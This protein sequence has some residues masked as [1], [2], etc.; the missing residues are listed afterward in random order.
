MPPPPPHVQV[1]L[2]QAFDMLNAGR[3]A[4]AKAQAEKILKA[5]PREPNALYLMGVLAHQAG[6]LKAAAKH[7]EKSFAADKRNPAALSGIG[8]V[9]LDQERF[10]EAVK[11]FEDL[12][13]QMPK[14][15]A[16]LNNLGVAYKGQQRYDRAIPALEAAIAA[17]PDYA[18]AYANLGGLFNALAETQKARKV[19]ETGAARCPRDTSI[20]L[21][22]AETLSNDGDLD[23]AI[24]TLRRALRANPAEREVRSR[25]ASLLIN[26]GGFDEAWS[27]LRALADEDPDDPKVWFDM[28][29]LADA[30]PEGAERSPA[31]FR[32]EGLAVFK[33]GGQGEPAPILAQRLAQ[34][35]EAEKDYAS[36]FRYYAKA[37]DAFKAAQRSVGNVYDRAQ[38]EALY[39]QLIEYFES[40][41]PPDPATI[42]GARA[43][44]RPIFILGMPR[45][46][47]SLLEQVLASHPAI[48]G[49]GELMTVPDLILTR[50]GQDG[51]VPGFI[52]GCDDAD[53]EA[54]AANYLAAL[55]GLD[56]VAD[57]VTDKLPTNFVNTGLIRLM[58]PDATIL[59][60][61]R[62][63]LDVSWSV[64]VQKFGANLLF[65][66]DLGDIGHYYRQYDR[67][68][69]FWRGW[70]P[71]ILPIRYED[72]VADMEATV[73]PILDR[74][75]LDWDPAMARFFETDREVKTASR[76]QVRR[77]IYNSS[78]QRWKRFEDRLGP[79]MAALGDLPER[80]ENRRESR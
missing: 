15:P 76:L 2:K 35:F 52:A 21:N 69:S 40:R 49:A 77:P 79:L 63:P 57:F 34:A 66:H 44:R 12:R 58:F 78:V 18:E 29:D 37:Q 28:A 25:L 17:R 48:H 9:R 59:N 70:D 11:I 53:L 62:H 1:Q 30:R 32:A 60:T 73:M 41:P 31:A 46:G 80:Y 50:L 36:A 64:Y 55:D 33:Q 10:A 3:T 19:L 7:F 24:D 6:D 8:I 16:V 20:L 75:G 14:E 74:L 26:K 4:E 61:E 22:L 43:S 65:D 47:T 5:L 51:D 67:L 13:R 38:T 72:T 39:D 27:I 68:M 42:S 23:G 54:M 45:S 56:P 71:S